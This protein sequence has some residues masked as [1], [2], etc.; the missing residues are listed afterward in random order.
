MYCVQ[1]LERFAPV[2]Y[3]DSRPFYHF[4]NPPRFDLYRSAL[5]RVTDIKSV[6]NLRFYNEKLKKLDPLNPIIGS[7]SMLYY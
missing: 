4:D 6:E 2:D 5:V 3:Y 1:D 7:L